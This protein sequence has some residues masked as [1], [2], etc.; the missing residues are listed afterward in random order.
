MY[1]AAVLLECGLPCLIYTRMQLTCMEMNNTMRA[2]DIVKDWGNLIIDRVLRNKTVLY[3]DSYYL[4]EESRVWLRQNKV[5]Y[6]A[7]INRGR[8]GNIVEN[9]SRKLEKSGTHTMAYNNAGLCVHIPSELITATRI[10]T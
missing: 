2:A 4:T 1:E 8:F 10:N 9:L 6:V 7:S 3:M 5:Q